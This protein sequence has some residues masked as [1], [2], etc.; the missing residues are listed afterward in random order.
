MHIWQHQCDTR[1]CLMLTRLTL[2]RKVSWHNATPLQPDF[3]T[4]PLNVARA[5]VTKPSTK[6]V[7]TKTSRGIRARVARQRS[8]RDMRHSLSSLSIHITACGHDPNLRY[9]IAVRARERKRGRRVM[10]LT[11]TITNTS[12]I[13][14]FTTHQSDQEVSHHTDKCKVNESKYC[15]NSLYLHAN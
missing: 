11:I 5:R 8:A 13:A 6:A 9:S 3:L 7:G 2:Y 12:T 14:L 10:P 15:I 4:K 1:S